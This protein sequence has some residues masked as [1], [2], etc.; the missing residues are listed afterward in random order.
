MK[1]SKNYKKLCLVLGLSGIVGAGSVTA[2]QATRSLQATY[3]DIKVTYNNVQQTIAQEPFSVDG[4]VYV[5]LRAISDIFGATANWQPTTNTVALSGGAS[6][7]TNNATSQA[8]ITNLNYQIAALQQELNAAKTELAQYK[9][10]EM[11]NN[12][13]QVN[14]NTSG[15][16]ITTDQLKVT[17]NELNTE[18]ADFFS[19]ISFYYTLSLSGNEI[20]VNI[21]YDTRSEN[22]SYE[23]LSTSKIET[24]MKKLGDFIAS[25]HQDIAIS[26][27]IEYTN[28]SLEK[29]SFTRSKTGKYSYAHSF[30]EEGIKEILEDE[31]GNYFYFNNIGFSSLYINS[32]DVAIRDAKSTVNVKLYLSPD[33]TFK[34]TWGQTKTNNLL[35]GK[36]T[37]SERKYA[38]EDQLEDLQE[39]LMDL[40]NGY[41]VNID[42][43]YNTTNVIASINA[44]GKVSTKTFEY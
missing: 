36:L 31:T 39:A 38:V 20:N 17:E 14:N 35:S 2:A 8:E 9:A 26:G 12:N 6:N 7:N 1:M 32:Y 41:E 10:N 23:K 37:D 18:Y 43:Y 30:D 21:A 28:E 22:T 24:Y 4:T 11:I 33:E 15:S 40:T 5:P 42:V 3:R 29:A 44:D 13:T 25:K 16:T 27:T 34:T 19:N